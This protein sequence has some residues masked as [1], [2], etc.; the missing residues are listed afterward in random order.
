MFFKDGNHLLF[1]VQ[2]FCLENK[3]TYLLIPFFSN[4]EGVDVYIFVDC[5][6][7]ETIVSFN[8]NHLL[9]CFQIKKDIGV[10]FREKKIIKERWAK[11]MITFSSSI[12]YFTKQKKIPAIE[13]QF[14]LATQLEGEKPSKR[15]ANWTN[16]KIG[17]SEDIF[18]V[19]S[20]ANGIA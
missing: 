11:T 20:D 16:E 7:K 6:H 18:F 4:H 13:F 17:K 8:D 5:S 14:F 19:F 3:K 12:N 15:W 1:I 9:F 10:C 2:N